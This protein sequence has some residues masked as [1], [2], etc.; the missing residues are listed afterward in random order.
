MEINS[1][2]KI[3]SIGPSLKKIIN[4]NLFGCYLFDDFSIERPFLTNH[5]WDNLFNSIHDLF[6]IKHEKSDLLL[7]GQ[8]EYLKDRKTLIFIG[9]PWVQSVD[10]LKEKKMFITDFA[11]HDPTFDLLHII[12]NI[13]INS[14]EIKILLSKLKQ[15]SELIKQ[16]EANYKATLNMASEIIYKT[17]RDGYFIYVNPAGQRF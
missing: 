10:S 12:K 5:N 13:E 9:T 3:T 15:K 8:F 14:E 7:R 16:S 1:D 2:L 17:N 4:G 11:I 6:I